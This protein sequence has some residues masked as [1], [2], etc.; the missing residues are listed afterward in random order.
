ML[1]E[2]EVTILKALIDEEITCSDSVDE[3]S[4]GV[5][6]EQYKISLSL[7]SKK[8]EQITPTSKNIQ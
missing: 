3:K 5:L 7:I 2:K 1:S 4:F 8:L 6:A